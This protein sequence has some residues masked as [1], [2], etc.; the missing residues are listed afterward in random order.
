MYLYLKMPSAAIYGS[1]AA[2][3][4]ILITTRRGKS[5]KT[6]LSYNFNQGWAQATV[7]PKLADAI[8]YGNLRNELPV[9]EN[10]P[11]GQWTAAWQALNTTGTYVRTDNGNTVTSPVGFFPEDMVKYRDGSD[12]W[13]HPNTD[14]YGDALKTWAPQQKHNLQINGGSENIRYLASLG[15]QNQDGYY[16]NSA[17]G[18][19]QYD[20]RI[21]VDA[22]INK[23]VSTAIG[24]TAREEYR[25]YPTESAGS[26]FRMLMRGKPNEPEIWPNGLPGR[27]IENGQNP[28]VI[29][30]NA[31]GYDK[32]KSDYF[33]TN[34]RLDIQI[35]G[36]AGSESV[37]FCSC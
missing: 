15:Y 8:E 14:W 20:M 31:T 13:G 36:V 11:V 28:I 9:F 7:I 18:Y 34:G 26:I 12:P 24:F 6:S 37:R 3:G 29:S 5:G 23:Y 21:N 2:N 16:K 17:T 30:T 33:Q 27:D 19:K 25:F 32:D 35:P 10:V 22:K 1:R 4:V